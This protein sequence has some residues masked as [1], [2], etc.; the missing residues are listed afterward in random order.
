MVILAEGR[1]SPL[2]SKTANGA[3]R[4]LPQQIVGI[5]DSSKVGKT[6]QEILGFGG[7]IPVFK[8]LEEALPRQP[9]TLL[10]GIAPTGGRL[11]EEW[12]DILRIGIEYG[13][14]IISGLHTFVSD[15][16]ELA[17]LAQERGVEVHDL[18]KVPPEYAVVSCGSWKT[19]RARTILT[20][21]TD[22]DIGKMTTSLEIHREMEQRGLKS[23]FV[24]TGQ[25]GILIAGK[26]IALDAVISDYVAGSIELAIDQCADGGADYIHVEGQGALTHQGYSGVTLGLIHGTMPD[27]MILVH[28]PSRKTDDYGFPLSNLK[29]FI[30]LHEDIVRIF[31]QTKV[32]G[33]AVNSIGLKN[34]GEILHALKQVERETGL[35]AAE[36]SRF[37]AGKL[38]DALM[39][40]LH[41]ETI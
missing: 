2:N 39:N 21:G 12:R 31:K 41:G 9:N 19:R 34:D 27:A 13:L 25:T 17:A 14:H 40:Y 24:A 11:P 15:D 28:Q 6:S 36:V 32:V 18:R 7:R 23:D 38:V 29:M 8:K 10:I 3:I 16:P 22:C 35:P 20:V 5:I 4:Y 37:G 33:I 30:R 1:F 26:G